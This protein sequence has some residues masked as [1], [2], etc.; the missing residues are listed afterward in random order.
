[1]NKTR[2]VPPPL[3]HVIALS[4]DTGIIQHAVCDVPNRSTGYCTDDVSR[5]FMVVLAKLQLDPRDAAAAR[6]AT[7]YLSFLHDAQMECGRFHNFMSYER[8]WLDDCGTQDSIGRAIWSLGYGIRCAPRDSWKQV[9]ALLLE[10]G[11]PHAGALEHIR[12]QAYAAIGLAHAITA[13]ATLNDV[14]L[15]SEREARASKGQGATLRMLAEKIKAAYF[16]HR[17]G[18]WQWF[19]NAMTYDNA[20]L[21]EAMLRAGLA[22]RDDELIAIGLRTLSFYTGVVMEDG[23]FVP[24][25]NDGWYERGGTRARYGQQPLEAAAM[26][27]A[28]LVAYD[29]TADP[30]FVAT[31]HTVLGWYHGRNLRGAVMVER[32]GCHD[33]LEEGEINQNM[34][35]ESTLAYLASAYALAER[36]A[37]SLTLAR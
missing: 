30:S 28:A 1:M 11:L 9:C 6:L 37:K 23:I 8:Q 10:R 16:A 19:E 26:I 27:D 22:L 33:G 14:T 7:I 24:I 15:R 34:G 3:D 31:A 32:G 18:E 29:C 13:R 4:D 17:D 5:A 25:G 35:A 21:C 36:P 20:R 12:S 2:V